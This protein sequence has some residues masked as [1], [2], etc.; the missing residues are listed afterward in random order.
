MTKA[1]AEEIKPIALVAIGVL[2]L[3]FCIQVNW[4]HVPLPR[5]FTTTDDLSRRAGASEESPFRLFRGALHMHTSYSDGN[6]TVA[7]RVANAK[8]VGLDFIIITDHSWNEKCR[9]ECRQYTMEGQ[10]LCVMGWECTTKTAH[11]PYAF[12]YSKPV[13]P[14]GDWSNYFSAVR[15]QDGFSWVA[16]PQ[17]QKDTQGQYPFDNWNTAMYNIS[18]IDGVE[19]WNEASSQCRPDPTVYPAGA[20]WDNLLSKGYGVWGVSAEDR[21]AQGGLGRATVTVY[22]YNLTLSSISQ[23]LRKGRFNSIRTPHV[24]HYQNFRFHVKT[25]ELSFPGS[26]VTILKGQDV[27]IHVEYEITWLKQDPTSRVNRVQVIRD[28]QILYDDSPFKPSIN[29]TIT[30]TPQKPSIYRTWVRDTAGGWAFSNPI[31]VNPVPPSYYQAKQLILQAEANITWAEE[32]KLKS[33]EGKMLLQQ[34]K[35]QLEQ[36]RQALN[37]NEYT[38]AHQL[39]QKALD[40]IKQSH[41]IEKR[42]IDTMVAISQ[43]GDAIKKAESDGRT[44]GLQQ[45]RE[46]LGLAKRWLDEYDYEKA[47]ILANQ[48]KEAAD[49]ATAPTFSNW[50]TN[51]WLYV[52]TL[53][54]V[55]A[56]AVFLASK[57]AREE[58]SQA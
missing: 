58:I 1:V 44:Q 26:T 31:F 42:Y 52:A 17:W 38:S 28:G 12:V 14:R 8:Q 32:A 10:F 29:L 53:L 16:H 36:A 37:A 43:A 4:A 3:S 56:G 33:P 27:T 48:A 55:I 45:A 34:A 50:L 9:D 20:I 13:S 7:G 46:Q 57:R 49:K 15:S 6:D 22:A 19:V 40:L 21:H 39:A 23:S 5:Q 11:A 35:S 30:D 2:L 18:M 25:S 41:F 54:A 24:G 47:V 51:N